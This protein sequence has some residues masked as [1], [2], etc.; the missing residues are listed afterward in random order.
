MGA[1]E[2]GTLG[3][4]KALRKELV[5]PKIADRGGR[6]V[7]LMGDG[8]LAEFP[9]VVEAVQCAVDVQKGMNERERELADD[10]RVRLRIGIN[11]GDVIVEGSDIYGDGV[12]VAA[13][14]EGLAAPG[15][16]TLSGPAYET[17]RG[18]LDLAFEDLGEQMVKNIEQPVRVYRVV[19][20]AP[21]ADQAAPPSEPALTLPDKP[22]LAV[23]PFVNMSADPEQDFFAEGI[24]EDIITELS[25]FRSLFVIARNS[26]FAFK[27]QALEVK[28]VGAKLGVRYLVEGSVRRAGQRVRI[29]AQLIDAVA[30]QHLWAERYDRDLAD[31]FALQDEVTAAIVTAI[32]PTLA[33]FER[34]RAR[35]APPERLDAWESYQRGLW[36]LHLYTA[37]DSPKALEFF[38][39]ALE[40]DP[41]FAA[42]HAGLAWALYY[43]IVLGFTEDR[44]ADLAR[45]LEAGKTAV[46]LDENDSFGHVALGRIHTVRGEHEAAIAICERAI[47]LNPNYAS[48]YFGRAHS[49]WQSG[50]PGEAIPAL[51]EAMRL[52]PRDPLIWAYKASKAMALILLGRYDEALD[53]AED[54][55][56]HPN[57]TIWAMLPEVSVLGLLGRHEKARA[58]FAR[59]RRL[60]PDVSLIL[61]DQAVIFSQAEDRERFLSGLRAAGMPG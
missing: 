14:L 24:A 39:R 51:D 37:E 60:K 33:N 41:T 15:G 49:L 11:L 6:I 10:E 22:S 1:D 12:N 46:L 34:Q 42:A 9:S 19:L 29:T 36:H 45:A 5:Q 3:R 31:I 55:Q 18:K 30:D 2:A 50:R 40:L 53:W 20:E 35:R 32:E 54:A 56:R 43:H 38:A 26:S 21:A 57:T 58:A 25:K 8:L 59:T 13:R 48:A 16:I 7:K 23:L 4:L 28:E 47:A 27:G 44:E 52:S 17:A 61:V